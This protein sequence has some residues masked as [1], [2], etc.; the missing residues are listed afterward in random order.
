MILRLYN[1]CA[2]RSWWSTELLI[3]IVRAELCY[4]CCMSARLNL[5]SGSPAQVSWPQ[6]KPRQIPHHTNCPAL[7][8]ARA[9]KDILIWTS[10]INSYFLL[11]KWHNSLN[12]QKKDEPLSMDRACAVLLKNPSR[13]HLMLHEHE[14]PS[15]WGDVRFT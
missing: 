12:D 14:V 13:V 6:D 7:P 5:Q 2:R 11:K 4:P 8:L 15:I 1:Y 10:A 3:W 9:Q